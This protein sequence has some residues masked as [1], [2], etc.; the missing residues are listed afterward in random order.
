[1]SLVSC[2]QDS[3]SD[4]MREGGGDSIPESWEQTPDPGSPYLPES[5]Q[6]ALPN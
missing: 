1:M 2:V 4:C 5:Q 3:M 6:C